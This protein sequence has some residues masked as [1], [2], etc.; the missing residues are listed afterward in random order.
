MAYTTE[1]KIEN[2]LQIDIDDSLSSQVSTWINWVKEWIDNY[3][4]TTFEASS[5]TR[6][7]DSDGTDRLFIDYCTSVSNIYF[8][9]SEGNVDETLSSSDY[10]LYP[11]NKTPK[12]EI[13]L[14]PSGDYPCFPVGSKRVK[15]VGTFGYS[16]NVPADIEW[17]ATGMVGEIIKN[18][19]DV[20]KGI[21]SENLGEYSITFNDI[22]K[23]AL[24]E[25]TAILDRYKVSN[26]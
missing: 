19:T 9:D 3:T 6:Y 12:Y 15:V 24:P 4:G 8:L 18:M 14:N 23:F 20:A 11:L 13:R 17:V 25:Y 26:F 22:Q 2:F 21:K 10:W 1:E 5:E 16:D 7:Y